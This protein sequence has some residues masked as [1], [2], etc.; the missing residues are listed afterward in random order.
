MTTACHPSGNVLAQQ[1]ANGSMFTNLAPKLE[2][3]RLS[4]GTTLENSEPSQYQE[5]TNNFSSSSPPKQDRPP[6]V[7]PERLSSLFSRVELA[8]PPQYMPYIV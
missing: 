5:H 6:E 2:A 1:G 4:D 3:L 8:A 7:D